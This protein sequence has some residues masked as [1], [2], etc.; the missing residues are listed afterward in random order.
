[1][2]RDVQVRFTSACAR[3]VR[4]NDGTTTL[5]APLSG[6]GPSRS[7]WFDSDYQDARTDSVSLRFTDS[8]GRNWQVSMAGDLEAVGARDW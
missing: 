7:A 6:L 3:W 8:D 1:V 4:L 5:R 2:I